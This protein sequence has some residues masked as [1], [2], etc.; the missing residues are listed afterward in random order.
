MPRKRPFNRKIIKS[1]LS[2]AIEQLQKLEHKAIE[3][4]LSEVELQIG[5]LHAYFHLNFAWNIRRVSTSEYTS[6]T[7]EQFDAWGNIRPQSK[8]FRRALYGS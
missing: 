7:Q 6:L 2:E 3:G 4:E 8:N 5:L 1:N